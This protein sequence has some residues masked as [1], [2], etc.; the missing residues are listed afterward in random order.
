MIGIEF[1]ASPDF[2][3]AESDVDAAYQ[4]RDAD[5]VVRIAIAGTNR[6]RRDG[7]SGNRENEPKDKPGRIQS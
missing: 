7:H 6:S 4:L 1:L 2:H 3:V 5:V